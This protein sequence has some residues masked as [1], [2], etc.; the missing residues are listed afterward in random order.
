MGFRFP[1]S[2]YDA[3]NGQVAGIEVKLI[4]P[5]FIAHC[6]G[7]YTPDLFLFKIHGHI[8]VKMGYRNFVRFGKRMGITC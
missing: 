8:K 5:S 3:F 6:K 4:R 2:E 7:C 1:F